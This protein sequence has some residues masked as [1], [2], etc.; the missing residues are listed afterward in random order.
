MPRQLQENGLRPKELTIPP[1]VLKRII[2]NY[3]QE[4]GLRNL[5]REIGALCRKV[6]RRLAEGEEPPFAVTGGNLHRYLGPPKYLP[7][8]EVEKD[9]VG[10]ATGLAWTQVG[11]ET[12]AVEASLMKGKGQLL[13]TG[14]LGDVMKESARRRSVISGPGLPS[15]I[16]GFLREIRSSYPRARRGYPQGWPLRRI[17]HAVRPGVAALGAAP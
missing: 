5:E 2:L 17:G 8:G 1:E 12:L 4:A 16:S 11:G 10:V 7:E 3:T 9:E 15:C 6:A 14:Q 13:L